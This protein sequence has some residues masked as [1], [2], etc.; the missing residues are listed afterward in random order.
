MS[1]MLRK[2]GTTFQPSFQPP[3]NSKTLTPH[4]HFLNRMKSNKLWSEN[5]KPLTPHL[6]Y[7]RLLFIETCHKTCNSIKFVLIK[8][9][10]QLKSKSNIS[11]HCHDKPKS[12]IPRFIV[13]CTLFNSVDS[14]NFCYYLYY[15]ST[16][17][18][19]SPGILQLSG[20]PL[21]PK[22]LRYPDPSSISTSRCY[23]SYSFTQQHNTT[24][25][26]TFYRTPN[27]HYSNTNI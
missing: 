10:T 5:S 27:T 24:F 16:T 23:Y 8:P 7:Y 13:S 20:L 19:T 17:I 26:E 22:I 21:R 11:P 14:F 6:L 9:Q 3:E 18:Q 2:A 4:L 15:N 25:L 1:S 12:P